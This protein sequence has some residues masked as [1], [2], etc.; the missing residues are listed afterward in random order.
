[1]KRRIFLTCCVPV[2]VA[3]LAIAAAETQAQTF[4]LRDI[5]D[6]LGSQ[7]E[8]SQGADVILQGITFGASVAT[9]LPGNNGASI[10]VIGSADNGFGVDSIDVGLDGGDAG[11]T[12]DGFRRR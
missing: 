1:M 12:I 5:D 11:A 3:L 6:S 9:T 8:D 4:V 7:L 2:F 10:N